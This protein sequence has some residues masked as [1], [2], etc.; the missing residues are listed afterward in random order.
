MVGNAELAQEYNYRPRS[1]LFECQ[2]DVNVQKGLHKRISFRFL[3][4]SL[5]AEVL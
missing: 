3:H 5:L 1:Q 4:F 2:R